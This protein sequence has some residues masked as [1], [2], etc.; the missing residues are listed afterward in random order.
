MKALVDLCLRWRLLVVV[1][2]TIVAAIGVRS[3]LR[4]PIDAVPDITNVQVQVLTDAAALGPVDVERTI[5]FPVESSMSGLPGVEELRSVSRFGLSAVTIVFEE[6]TDLLRARQLVSERLAQA[7][8]RLPA[9]AVPELGPLSSGLGEILQFEL[10]ADRL[11]APGEPS[12]EGCYSSMDLR[13]MLDWFVAYELRSVPGVVEV[14]SFG[15]ELKTYEVEV[16]PNRL[17]ALDVSL[18]QLFDAIEKNNATA[19]GGY[20]VR[21]GEQL[22]VRGEGR[23]QSLEEVGDVLI[24]TRADGVPVR[25]RDVARVHL[26]PMLRQGAVTRDGRGEVVTG[27]VM[28]LVGANG[29]EVV[30]DVKGKIAQISPSLPPGVHIDVFYDRAEL[31]NRTIRTVAKNLAEGALFVVAVLFLL[32][33]SIRGGLIVAVTIPFALLVAFTAMKALGLSGNLMSLGAIDFGIVVDGSIIVVENAV[34]RLS[35]AARGQERAMSYEEAAR[36]VLDSTLDVSKAAVFGGVII[37]IVYVPI[38]TLS[39]IE[40]KMFEPMA[41]TVLFALVG[42]FAASLTLVPVL[43]ATFLRGR[44]EAREPLLV[45]LAHRV[46]PRL[47][48]PL[49]AAPKR[50]MAVAALLLVAALGLASRMGGEFIPRLDEG[51]LAIQ[52][53]RLPSVSLEESLASAT[54]FEK[55]IGEFPEVVTVVSKTGRAEIATD[56]MGVELSDCMVML[57]PEAEWK[58][59]RTREELIARM[60][61]RFAEALPGLGFSFSQPI[62]LRMAEL[63]SGSRSDVALTIYGDDLAELERLSH[64]VQAV[65]R[66]V[67]GATDVRGEQLAGLPTLEVTVD[68]ALASRYGVSIRDALDAI[69]VLGGREVGEV[70]EGERRY[71]LQVR[72]PESMRDDIAQVR[73][74]PVS[75]ESGPLVPL[76]Q[77]ASIQVVDSPASVSREAARRRT[78]VEVNVRGRDLASFVGEARARVEREVRTS[79][80]TVLRW[81]G[82][83][84]NLSAATERLA[85][86]VPLALGLVFVLLYMAFG[87]L[88]AALI[89][90]LNVPFAAVGGVFLLAARGMPFSISA[91]IGFI[92]LFGIAVLN[93]VVLLSTV[94]KL[95]ARGAAPED[96]AREGAESR[97]RAVLMTAAVAALGFAPMALSSSAGAE[98]Q[99]PLAT[100]VIGGLVSATFLTLFVVPTLYAFVYRV[101]P[102]RG[103]SDPS[104][105]RLDI[106]GSGP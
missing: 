57:K 19:G 79:P 75:G 67:P 23:I 56:P 99:R 34:V 47:L 73:S 58:T 83:F 22:L 27:I 32:L 86:A 78:N 101:R 48:R 63:I 3:A 106:P 6:G 29:R 66:A 98:V 94:K 60:S 2:A 102:A 14:N 64:E 36:V 44:A 5:T 55:V 37:V 93:G 30:E 8:E 62:E 71:R 97:L 21:S 18:N 81:S 53:L 28:M 9:G 46:Y 96:A 49:M 70:Y 41:L 100:V 89:I 80:G 10:R 20:L 69:E 13:S 33:G 87:E 88:R 72:V 104:G 17:R 35:A 25:V 51:A 7:K 103:A 12:R 39:G 59:A 42:A 15:G 52:I 26:A 105:A 50:V 85:V 38:L 11:C 77:I 43:V 68:R 65:L 90:Y 24:E 45:R 82:Q 40:G 16:L 84:E 95:R 92:A 61:E 74:L 1:F 76:G 31:V 54:R 4:L 91:G